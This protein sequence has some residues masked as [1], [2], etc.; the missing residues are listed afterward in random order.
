MSTGYRTIVEENEMHFKFIAEEKNRLA[1]KAYTIKIS[2][3]TVIS[4]YVIAEILLRFTRETSLLEGVIWCSTIIL[5]I[6]L[7]LLLTKNEFILHESAKRA[8]YG[9]YKIQLIGNIIKLISDRFVY[10]PQNRVLNRIIIE[11]E[12]FGKISE[13]E[14]RNYIHGLFD[15]SE[16]QM[17]ELRLFN[18]ISCVFEGF[19]VFVSNIQQDNV[20]VEAII[21]LNGTWKIKNDN[22]FIAFKGMK[23]LFEI[24]IEKSN[25]SINRTKSQMDFL[26]NVIAIA[27]KAINVQLDSQYNIP[28]FS[29]ISQEIIEDSKTF[30]S[31]TKTYVLSPIEKRIQNV[32]I[33]EICYS[34]LWLIVFVLVT[35]IIGGLN[36]YIFLL[37]YFLTFLFYYVFFETVYSKTIGK[38]ITRTKVLT[39]AGEKPLLNTIIKR[40]FC[41]LIPFEYYSFIDKEIGIHDK[42]SKTVVIIDDKNNNK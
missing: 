21:K 14:G 11:S 1:N 26:V 17:S 2:I 4:L 7:L 25:R 20:D 24:Q 6:F 15:E 16:I 5:A 10:K 39:T 32:W 23:K 8:F 40:T 27:S 31:G 38:F 28:A 41:R 9:T 12:L 3:F 19:F 34:L 35:I 33:D 42:Y 29:R 13:F 37:S 22:L 30:T 36:P 18:G